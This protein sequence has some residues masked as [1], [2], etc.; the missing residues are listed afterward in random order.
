MFC[1]PSTERQKLKISWL[2]VL[3]LFLLL[4]QEYPKTVLFY[5]PL[6]QPELYFWLK[7]KN[8]K[9]GTVADFFQICNWIVMWVDNNSMSLLRT[10]YLK[11][12]FYFTFGS[13]IL[14]YHWKQN[15]VSKVKKALYICHLSAV[16]PT[17]VTT[18]TLM[19]INCKTPWLCSGIWCR[20][21]FKPTERVI[22]QVRTSQDKSCS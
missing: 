18:E 5:I 9:R 16:H 1:N 8:R 13:S 2:V 15:K 21:P 17:S 10:S 7:K 6:P 20:V 19:T 11:G 22:Q 12:L 3:L 4:T 14:Q